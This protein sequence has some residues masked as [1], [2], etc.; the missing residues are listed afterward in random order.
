MEK[1]IFPA[2]ILEQSAELLFIREKRLSGLIYLTLLIVIAAA[3]VAINFIYIDVNVQ[4]SG[5]IKPREDHTVITSTTNGFAEECRLIPNM[6]VKKGDTLLIIRSE[7]ITV[8]YGGT[9]DPAYCYG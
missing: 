4:A 9:L 2:S 8:Y 1:K 3:L 7:L 6:R 5:I